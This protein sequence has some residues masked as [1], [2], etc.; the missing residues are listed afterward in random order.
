MTS[1]PFNISINEIKNKGHYGYVFSDKIPLEI[2][3]KLYVLVNKLG[4]LNHKDIKKFIENTNRESLHVLQGLL[5]DFPSSLE[6][7]L[8]YYGSLDSLRNSD[9]YRRIM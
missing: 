4:G 3:N 2:D 1:G 5:R 7:L 9:E 8:Y 6:E